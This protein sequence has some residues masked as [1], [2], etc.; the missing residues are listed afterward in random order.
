GLKEVHLV[1]AELDRVGHELA[2]GPQGNDLDRLV[3]RHG[4]LSAR[5]ELLGGWESGRRVET[6]LSGIGLPRTLWD[7]EANMLSG[8]EKSRTALARELVSTPD[9]LLLDEPTN[10]LDLDGI[11]WL[12]TYL[13]SLKSAVLM[14]SHDR[15]LLD[16]LVSSIVEIENGRL[17]RYRGNHEH[18]VA[19]KQEHYAAALRAW[20][21]QQGHIRK[22]EVFIKKHMGSQRTAEA[23]G[24]RKRLRS[25][26]RLERPYDDVRK[27]VIAM[28]GTQR[29]GELVVETEDLD[30]G[31]DGK[32]VVHGAKLRVGRGERIGFVGP[33]GSGKTS[34]LRV[35][36]GRMQPLGGSIDRGHKAVCGYYDQETGNLRDDSSPYEEIRRD[37]PRMTDLEIRS[38]LARFLFRG[39]DVDKRVSS[40]S[41]GERARLSLAQLVLTGPSWLALDEPTNHLDLSGRTAMEEMLGTFDGALVC[42]SHDR[43]FLD[44]LCTTILEVK[45]GRVRAFRGNYSDYRAKVL[46]EKESK[47][48]RKPGKTKEKKVAKPRNPWRLEKLEG[49]IMALESEREE[50][51]AQMAREGVYRDPQASRNM[52]FRLAEVERDLEQKNLEWEQWG[53]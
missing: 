33:N 12:E 8:G 34:L 28:G 2:E 39:E 19:R 22:E 29:G 9:L 7:R 23:K 48:A 1:E 32:P 40:L 17:T 15:R 38:H 37:H 24:R 20:E 36:A 26:E 46:A 27:P 25:L 10:H 51:H 14:V 44:G 49:T 11:E 16:R 21:H 53:S 42:I 13:L 52:Q 3:E 5:M 45:D 4:E 47:P 30:V 41:G 18:Y 31:Y 50:L 43:T 6:V 35:L